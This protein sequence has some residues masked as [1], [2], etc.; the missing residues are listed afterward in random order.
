M[1]V[2]LVNKKIGITNNMNIQ[3]IN[4][5]SKTPELPSA[6]KDKITQDVER[7]LQHFEQAL[8]HP[9]SSD[10]STRRLESAVDAI[11][12]F[13]FSPKFDRMG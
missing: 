11:L 5:G 12:D 1:N 13:P 9:V 3:A 7:G 8:Q 4:F 2:K 10:Q 6:I